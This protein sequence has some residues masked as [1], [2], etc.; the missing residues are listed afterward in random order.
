MPGQTAQRGKPSSNKRLKYRDEALAVEVR[1]RHQNVQVH[2]THKSQKRVR[3]NKCEN[4]L[5]P[6]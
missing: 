3:S 5:G 4:E 1:A 2:P 6:S